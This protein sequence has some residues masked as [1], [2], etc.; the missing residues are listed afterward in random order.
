MKLKIKVTK[1]IL[2]ESSNC[3]TK[4]EGGVN[5][6]LARA[7]RD[8]LPTSS[9]QQHYIL[10]CL[11]KS[12]Q[13]GA[14]GMGVLEG[15]KKK[16]AIRTTFEMADFI[17]LFDKATPKERLEM[18]EQ[19]FELDLPD[20]VIDMIGDGNVEE[21]KKIISSSKTLELCQ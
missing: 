10:P 21:V 16:L 20:W 8:I 4:T 1:E 2:Q 14:A 17:E 7:V 13:G 5:C 11:Y 6:A 15:V 12:I 18:E 19:E 9:V 3:D